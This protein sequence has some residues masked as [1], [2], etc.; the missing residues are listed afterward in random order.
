[1][2]ETTEEAPSPAAHGAK[3]LGYR[4]DID[5]LRAVAVM[6]V[7]LFHAGVA[8][9]EG[10]Y[11]GVDVFFVISGFLITGLLLKEVQ[12]HQRVD[13]IQFWLRRARRL[14]PA[15]AVVVMATV[16][17]A[18]LFFAS[19]VTL[20][21][22]ARQAVTATLYVSNLRFATTL[23]DYFR[24]DLVKSSP[25]LHTWSLGIEEQFYLLWPLLLTG[26]VVAARVLKR[27]FRRIVLGLMI[28]VSVV[29]L[30]VCVRLS[31]AGSPF[32]FFGLHARAWE[33][34]LAGILAIFPGVLD[35][36]DARAR[37]I[38]GWVGVALV[39]GSGVA[40]GVDT[41]YPGLLV[42]APV[43]GTLLL[44]ASGRKADERSPARLLD[45]NVMRALGRLS[46]AWYLWHWPLLVFLRARVEDPSLGARVGAVVLS[47]GLAFVTHH[48][49]EN[50]IR[51]SPVLAASRLKT[52]A[53]AAAFCLAS[54]ALTGVVFIG[55]KAQAKE[56]I[57]RDVIAAT[58]DFGVRCA[59]GPHGCAHG[60]V[61]SPRAVFLVGDSHAEQWLPALD[62]A[63]KQMGLRIVRRTFR[64]CPAYNVTL[65]FASRTASPEACNR[66]NRETQQL[67]ASTRPVA[68]LAGA[69]SGQYEF[70][71]AQDRLARRHR[72][73]LG[74][75]DCGDQGV[76]RTSRDGRFQVRHPA[77]HPAARL[78]PR[79]VRRAAP[80]VHRVRAD[81]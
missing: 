9:F 16:A 24:A 63:G 54:L 15:L 13:L 41:Q 55:A 58:R 37:A 60:D 27:E 6:L 22:V 79:G 1:M 76:R 71:R 23:Q 66:H 59:P 25:F 49:V 5:G 52:A 68:V 72:H 73:E 81:A 14:F 69:S 74:G 34:G 50:P 42:L 78:R 53:V 48:T 18:F 75:V 47:L 62:A 35:R 65:T 3:S 2:T 40:Y 39:L 7:V 61:N 67:I 43:V 11:V 33:F 31:D 57:V 46:F 38:L 36:A 20:P 30:V 44:I 26:A 64:G 12:R 10:G 32:A 80:V 17:L 19:P 21:E 56:P 45:T 8:P 51:F 29:S 4:G 77:R 70:L 28:V